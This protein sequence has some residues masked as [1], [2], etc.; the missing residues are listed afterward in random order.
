MKNKDKNRKS[1]LIVEDQEASRSQLK[2][3]FEDIYDVVEAETGEK[4]LEILEKDRYKH[5]I[6][7]IVLDLLMPGMTGFD[8]LD[9]IKNYQRIRNTLSKNV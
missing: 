6:Y 5:T 7:L 4:A 8:V 3:L 9:K 2:A 1:I